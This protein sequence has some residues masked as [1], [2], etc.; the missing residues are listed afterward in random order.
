MVEATKSSIESLPH[1]VV[2][3]DARGR[4]TVRLLMATSHQSAQIKM[5]DS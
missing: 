5:E 4:L 3:P 1:V 2:V